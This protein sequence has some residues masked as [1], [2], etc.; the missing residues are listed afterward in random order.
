LKP[1]AQVIDLL[2]PTA[3]IVILLAPEVKDERTLGSTVSGSS[4]HAGPP[5]GETLIY[6]PLSVSGGICDADNK[7]A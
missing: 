6:M 5:P 4:E 7:D 2:C 1:D 3:F